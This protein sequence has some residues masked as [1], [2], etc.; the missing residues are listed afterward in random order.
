MNP[1]RSDPIRIVILRSGVIREADDSRRRAC[2]EPAEGTYAFCR[3][4]NVPVMLS[5]VGLSERRSYTVEASL[6]AATT[7]KPERTFH[8]N[9]LSPLHHSTMRYNARRTPFP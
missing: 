3:S 9:R 1:D 8:A 2:P 5:E 7:A 4:L 6:P